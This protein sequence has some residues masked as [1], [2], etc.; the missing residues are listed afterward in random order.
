MTTVMSKE[1]VEGNGFG[2]PEGGESTEAHIESITICINPTVGQER[3][4]DY[5]VGDL[6][7]DAQ[8]EFV[9]HTV[10]CRYCLKEVV[11][12]RTAQVLVEEEEERSRAASQ[13]T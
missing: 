1:S 6:T 11:S 2:I 9:D 3:V 7:G 10:E 5:I 8:R 13:E 4:I 12:W